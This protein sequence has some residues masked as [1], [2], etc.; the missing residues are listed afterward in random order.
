MQ[1]QEQVA[2]SSITS[3]AKTS[4]S[5]CCSSKSRIS[6]KSCSS[7]SKEWTYNEITELI[8]IWEGEEALY[9]L[10]HPDYSIKEIMKRIN[11]DS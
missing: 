2:V 4:T 9:N 6:N 8:T 3:V 1:N 5:S 10:R 11:N 7:G